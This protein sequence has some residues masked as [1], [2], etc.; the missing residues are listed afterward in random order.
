MSEL[1]S[2]PL[3][4]CRAKF[5]AGSQRGWFE[6]VFVIL[7]AV[8]MYAV[9]VHFDARAEVKELKATVGDLHR[10]FRSLETRVSV[11]EYRIGAAQSPSN[12]PADKVSGELGLDSG[13]IAG[14]KTNKEAR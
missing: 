13:E 6:V 1:L 7:L 2:D 10:E 11:L 4:K 8:I 5:L 9:L 12:K 3:G 14:S